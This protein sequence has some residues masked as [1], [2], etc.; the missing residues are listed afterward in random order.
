MKRF[1]IF[2]L[3]SVSGA[4]LCVPCA[5]EAS[6]VYDGITTELGW[7][8]PPF[9]NGYHLFF[10][11]I[12]DIVTIGPFV[13][14]LESTVEVWV[15]PLHS[16][17]AEKGAV[18]I[19]GGGPRAYCGTGIGVFVGKRELCYETDPA[20]CGNDLDICVHYKTD[21]QWVHI[22]GTFD[23]NTSRIFVNGKMINELPNVRFDPGD[24]LTLGAYQYGNGNQSHFRGEMDEIRIWTVARS[25]EEI[26]R[27]MR[28]SLKGNE[29]GLIAYWN[30]DA[31][32]GHRLKNGVPGQYEGYLGSSAK[33]HADAPKWIPS[34]GMA[35][36]SGFNA[37]KATLGR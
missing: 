25:E 26:F 16:G 10:D 7:A 19:N 34:G 11:G 20:G 5:L 6:D 13:P 2:L 30:C 17:P 37:K 23:G 14:L 27:T 33:S 28:T 3:L 9:K 4:I 1:W 15:R 32:S 18:L 31:G 29:P 22:A 36:E 21:A 8:D 12:D 35:G 24:W